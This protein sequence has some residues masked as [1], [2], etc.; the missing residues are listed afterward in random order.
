MSVISD[1]YMNELIRSE[2]YRAY[3][4]IHDASYISLYGYHKPHEDLILACKACMRDTTELERALDALK[5]AILHLKHVTDM[6][7]SLLRMAID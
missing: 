3:N 2:I 7:T 1:N 4:A 5:D 6:E